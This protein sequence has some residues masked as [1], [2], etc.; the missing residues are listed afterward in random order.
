MFAQQGNSRI[1]E[2]KPDFEVSRC[3]FYQ[4][5]RKDRRGSMKRISHRFHRRKSWHPNF[6]IGHGESRKRTNFYRQL[7]TTCKV[8][9]S[10]AKTLQDVVGIL[11]ILCILSGLIPVGLLAASPEHCQEKNSWPIVT[12]K[13]VAPKRTNLQ[14]ES[15]LFRN[16]L[17]K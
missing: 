2:V 10:V 12:S 8:P 4:W 17:P 6:K 14:S 7:L 1:I 13:R 11:C 5:N 15:K 3:Y 9:A 16:I